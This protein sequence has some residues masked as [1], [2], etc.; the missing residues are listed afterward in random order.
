M[1]VE[2]EDIAGLVEVGM[3]VRVRPGSRGVLLRFR[4]PASGLVGR[5]YFPDGSSIARVSVRFSIP[6]AVWGEEAPPGVIGEEQ[7]ARVMSALT[8]GLLPRSSRKAGRPWVLTRVDVFVDVMADAEELKRVYKMA[9]HP[10]YRR[11]SHEFCAPYMRWGRAGCALKFYAKGRQRAM[12]A[13]EVGPSGGIELVRIEL[14]VRSPARRRWFMEAMVESF[15]GDPRALWIDLG[16]GKGLRCV[17]LDFATLLGV[18]R[19][20]VA[21]VEPTAEEEA[22]V[23]KARKTRLRKLHK[24]VEN[25][26]CA[27]SEFPN[28]ATRKRNRD[29]AFVLAWSMAGVSLLEAAERGIA[30]SAADALRGCGEAEVRDGGDL[31]EVVS[32]AERVG[33]LRGRVGEEAG[34]GEGRPLV[35]DE[36]VDV[37]ERRDVPRRQGHSAARGFDDGFVAGVGHAGIGQG[38]AQRGDLSGASAGHQEGRKPSREVALVGGQVAAGG[39]GRQGRRHG[40][41]HAMRPAG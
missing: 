30:A 38:A 8:A 31:G 17:A 19:S 27:A 37:R 21:L 14:T 5:I 16:A 36:A 6:R 32:T 24:L 9:R 34:E 29:D 33:D 28:K 4:H 35:A 7:A 22:G 26:R 2:E 20:E 39:V 41:Q 11:Q 40:G 25:P 23:K 18:L 13:G 12:L 15:R 1:A 10:H 3:D